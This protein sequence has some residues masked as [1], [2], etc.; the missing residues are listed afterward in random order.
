MV[1]VEIVRKEAPYEFQASDANGFTIQM[2]AARSFGGAGHGFSP[3][4]SL[5]AALGGCSGIDVVSILSKQRQTISHFSISIDGTREPGVE[6]SLWQTV[7]VRF[8][9]EGQIEPEKAKRACALSMD[10]YCSVAAT[11]RKAGCDITW[12]VAVNESE[13]GKMR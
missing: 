12:E 5:L 13:T 6:P 8:L 9:L 10:K 1:H 7:H 3:M 2:D 4:Q 11:L